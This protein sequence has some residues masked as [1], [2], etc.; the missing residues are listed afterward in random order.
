[1]VAIQ[2][3]FVDAI[4][5]LINNGANVNARDKEGM[6]PLLWAIQGKQPSLVTAML[7]AG[8][9]VH[10]CHKVT[11]ISLRCPCAAPMRCTLLSCCSTLAR[12]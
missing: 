8:A 12:P 4:R 3:R 5:V 9:D 10:A 11:F 1:M 7:D 6:T 2:K